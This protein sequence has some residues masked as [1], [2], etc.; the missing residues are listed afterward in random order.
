MQAL[1]N[2][3]TQQRLHHAYLFTGTRGVGKTTVSRILAKSLN[4]TGARRQGG[5]TAAALR[6]VRGLHATSTPAASS[7]TS[8]STRPPTAA[9]TRSASCS[10]RP[11]TSRRRPL[12]G[13]HDRRSA[14]AHQ[15]R[16][17]RDAED[18]RGAARVPEV[19]AGDDRSAEGAGDGAV[20]LPAVQ[21]AADGAADACTSTWRA[22]SAPEQ[23]RRRAGALRLLARAARGSMRDAL[24]LTDQA[25][26][27]GGGRLEEAGVRAMLGSVDRGHAVRLRRGAGARATAP[28]VVGRRRRRCATLGLSAAGTL[29]EM[30]ALLQQ[31][32]VR[33]PCR[34]R[35][36]PTIPTRADAARL[37]RCCRPTRRSCSTAS[38]LHGRAELRLAPD[39]YA[40]LVMVL[41]RMLAFPPPGER[42][43]AASP[44]RAHRRRRP[45]APRRRRPRPR[46]AVAPPA[47]PERMPI[48]P[49]CEP[50]SRRRGSTPCRDEAPASAPI[51]VA[52][53][54]R[55]AGAA[56]H[57]TRRPLGG[58]RAQMVQRGQHRRAGA[59]T[60]D[61]GRV[62][63]RCEHAAS[64]ACW[65]L[66]VEREI[67][68]QRRRCARS[69][70]RRWPTPLGRA[71]RLELEAGGRPTRRRCATPP[72]ASA[73]QAEA[74]Q[75]IHDDPLVQALM[76][77]FKTARIV[78]GSVKPR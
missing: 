44:E 53:R 42:T 29:E 7:T 63:R 45:P 18:A 19:R 75:I 57:A 74:E 55:G 49:A 21:P 39:E 64:G 50:R 48:D 41:L 30:A 65:R 69:C 14:H 72:S 61:A 25:I 3:L 43:G 52:P 70:R 34:A 22:C 20:A 1:A 36:T 26:A 11:S 66:R 78:P 67:A 17:Q 73:G 16:V 62:D 56:S 28:R 59:R 47:A 38:S 23:R 15:G 76:A 71:V 5:I 13:L 33:R 68:A 58:A 37:R 46:A 77:Q 35:S 27:F 40:A 24:S 9:S 60:G 4:C 31:M 54:R 8:S 6:R 2:A 12:Q 10:S 51:A 32:A